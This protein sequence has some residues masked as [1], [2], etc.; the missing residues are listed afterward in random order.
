MHGWWYMVVR[1]GV[2]HPRI[3]RLYVRFAHVRET[4]LVGWLARG[5][6]IPHRNLGAPVQHREYCIAQE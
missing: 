5:P 3:H 1:R 6:Q 2:D 4:K